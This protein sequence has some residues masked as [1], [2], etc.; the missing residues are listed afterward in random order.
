MF[1]GKKKKE[2]SSDGKC[3]VLDEAKQSRP[4]EYRSQTIKIIDITHV[5]RY[6][7]EKQIGTVTLTPA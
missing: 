6:G 5:S 2:K 4:P 1:L 7:S 3:A